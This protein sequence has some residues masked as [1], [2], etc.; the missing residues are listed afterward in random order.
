MSDSRQASEDLKMTDDQMQL[1]ELRLVVIEEIVTSPWPRRWLLASRL[2]KQL[3][4]VMR[5]YKWAGPGFAD[6]R[7]Q[8][9]SELLL[10]NDQQTGEMIP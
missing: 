1:L 7:I 3:R 6:R 10:I 8:Q 2:R 4:Q 5:D 9:Q